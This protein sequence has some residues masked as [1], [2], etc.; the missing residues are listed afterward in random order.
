M[1]TFHIANLMDFQLSVHQQLLRQADATT[2]KFETDMH[3]Q[4]N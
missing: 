2:I 4:P 1:K 3:R